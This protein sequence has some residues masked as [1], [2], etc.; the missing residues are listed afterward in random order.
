MDLQDKGFNSEELKPLGLQEN[1]AVAGW[2]LGTILAFAW[3]WSET[4]KRC[5]E[6]TCWL[7]ASI[8]TAEEPRE[9]LMKA[10]IHESD[11]YKLNSYLTENTTPLVRFEKEREN[12]VQL[13][14]N[15]RVSC[16]LH[17]QITRAT[18]FSGTQ[19]RIYHTTLH[20]ILWPIA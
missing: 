14:Q 2:N 16:C 19:T 10:K 4:R 9:P 11:I 17:L 18:D 12:M 3:R 5:M 1:Q 15:F 6:M 7:L 20:H 8:S 13:Y